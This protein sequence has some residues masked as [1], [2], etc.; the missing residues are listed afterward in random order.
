MLATNISRLDSL[1]AAA[2]ALFKIEMYPSSALYRRP[3]QDLS[4]CMIASLG[5]Y[6]PSMLHGLGRQVQFAIP[7]A[8]AYWAMLI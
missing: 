2:K 5:C 7:S 3:V 1:N 8:T 6:F 4:V